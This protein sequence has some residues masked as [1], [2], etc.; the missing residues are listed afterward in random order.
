MAAPGHSPVPLV[1]ESEHERYEHLAVLHVLPVCSTE[2]TNIL[3]LLNLRRRQQKGL[4]TQHHTASNPVWALEEHTPCQKKQRA[5]QRKADILEHAS[6]HKMGRFLDPDQGRIMGSSSIQFTL[7]PQEMYP[8]YTRDDASD[9]KNPRNDLAHRQ[10]VTEPL[11]KADEVQ[12][13]EDEDTLPGEKTVEAMRAR[14][15]QGGS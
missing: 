5:V 4:R 6:R 8:I 12:K 3:G 9:Q 15:L 10:R 1:L 7:G 2:I 13:K 14:D 11:L